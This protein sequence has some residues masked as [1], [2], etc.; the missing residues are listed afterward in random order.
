MAASDKAEIR[1]GALA[2]RSAVPLDIRQAFADRLA[3]LGPALVRSEQDPTSD[4]IVAAFLPIRDEPDTEPLLAVLSRIGL[5]TALPVAGA[6]G[7]PLVFRRW[8][9]GE[10]LDAGRWGL[11]H[12]SDTAPI[13]TP[14]ALFVP[15]AAFDR[16]GTRIGY[17]GGYYDATLQALRRS[18]KPVRAIGVAFAC[19][20]ELYLPAEDHDEPLDLIVTE[21]GITL[22]EA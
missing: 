11:R 12:P 3:T 19:Q 21:R 16:R 5:V 2:R 8:A 14:T 20:E 17:G 22:C 6:H 10:A 9:S 7:T 1:A 18:G 4:P 15:L 13:V